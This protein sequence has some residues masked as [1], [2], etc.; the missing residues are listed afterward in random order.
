MSCFPAFMARIAALLALSL[1]A[2][3]SA[4]APTSAPAKARGVKQARSSSRPAAEGRRLRY[5]KMIGRARALLKQAPRS[6][7]LY[8]VL[9]I[10]H[11]GLGDLVAAERAFKRATALKPGHAGGTVG[12]GSL[13]LDRNDLRTAERLL[14]SVLARR[15]TYVPALAEMSRLHKLRAAR[16]RKPKEAKKLLTVAIGFMNRAVAA[17]P[18][19]HSLRFRLGMLH[20]A[21]GDYFRSHVAFL[22]AV[23]LLPVQPCYRLGLAMADSF[24]LPP[25]RSIPA[26]FHWRRRCA[27]PKVGALADRAIL[28]VGLDL[29]RRATANRRLGESV[30]WLRRLEK[31]VPRSG[32]VQMLLGLVLLARGDCSGARAAV[33]KAVRLSPSNPTVR[34]MLKGKALKACTDGKA[35]RR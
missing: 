30:L 10:L 25:Q 9:G 12:L 3:G 31:R 13:A 16:S 26:L 20:L 1:P 15:K 21:A 8:A 24:L 14:R 17:G 22:A 33:R 32:E 6:A 18:R 5:R 29:V 19:Q 11:R 4:A 7:R 28:S 2:V 23:R 27:N 35:P 34:E